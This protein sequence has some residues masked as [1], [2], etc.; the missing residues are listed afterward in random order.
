[1]HGTF[2]ST[3]CDKYGFSSAAYTTR[4]SGNTVHFQAVTRSADSTITWT[5]T[6][7][8]DHVRG[9]AILKE[10]GKTTDYVFA[11]DLKK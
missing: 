8:G 10:N 4:P 3:A 1:M 5:G 2:H 11:G 6:V 7:E 9:T